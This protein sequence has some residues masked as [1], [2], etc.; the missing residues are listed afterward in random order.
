MSL[1]PSG[2]KVRS[3]R[4]G[5]FGAWP[6]AVDFRYVHM[7]RRMGLV[8]VVPVVGLEGPA[9]VVLVLVRMVA[10]GLLVAVGQLEHAAPGPGHAR[11]EEHHNKQRTE[12]GTDP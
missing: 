6:G 5:P 9:V 11:Q 3:G 12:D 8:V 7:R 2:V 10:M 4:G 1:G